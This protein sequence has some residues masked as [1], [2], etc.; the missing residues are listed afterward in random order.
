MIHSIQNK[1]MS[2]GNLS[3]FFDCKTVKYIDQSDNSSWCVLGF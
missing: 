2:A 3:F 1:V